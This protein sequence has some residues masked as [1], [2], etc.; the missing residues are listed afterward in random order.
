MCQIKLDFT[1]STIR[2]INQ[3]FQASENE[4]LDPNTGFTVKFT[5]TQKQALKNIM[6]EHNI[7]ASTFLRE[8]MDVYIEIFPYRD[9]IK[10]HKGLLNDLFKIIL[11]NLSCQVHF[12]AIWCTK[13]HFGVL[14]GYLVHLR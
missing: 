11:K 14:R 10:R 7:Q 4:S 12:G 1:K 3:Y 2:N 5:P 9:K 8:A 6:R 13:V